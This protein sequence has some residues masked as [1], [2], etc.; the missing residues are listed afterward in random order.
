MTALEWDTV[1]ERVYQT[2]VDRGVLYLMDGTAVA[3]NGIT[4]VEDGSD[5]EKNSYYLDGV[6]FFESITPGDFSGRLKAIT[7]P[8]EFERVLGNVE[9]PSGVTFHEQ[10]PQR[11]NLSYRTM[12]GTDSEGLT[13]YKIHLLYNLVA[14]PDSSAFD[15]IGASVTPVEFAWSLTG[16]PPPVVGMRPTVHVSIDTRDVGD[17]F[18]EYIEDILYGTPSE[19]PRFPTMDELTATDDIIITDHGDGTWSATDEAGEFIT[20]LDADTFQITDVDATYS[21]P[22]TYDVSSTNV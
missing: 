10:P 4:G 15:S 5:V 11:F 13:E 1:G 20:M 17:G 19:A 9:S 21:D 2:G 16:T 14:V 7:Y 12:I 6:K 3:W 18:L 8:D 22:D